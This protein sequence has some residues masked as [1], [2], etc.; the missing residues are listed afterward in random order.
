MNHMDVENTSQVLYSDIVSDNSPADEV[1]KSTAQ[2]RIPCESE[3][4]RLRVS[5]VVQGVGFRP[6]VY[7]IATALGL[8]GWVLNDPDGVLIEIEA[9]TAALDEFFR[10]L[11]AEA[12]PLAHITAVVTTIITSGERMAVATPP[13]SGFFIRASGQGGSHL[14]LVPPD[15]HVCA[16]CLAEMRDS[17]GR[18]YGYPFINC[19]NCG[20]RYSLIE[21]LPYDRANTTM[22]HFLMCSACQS[23]Y[24]D[25]ADRRY[26]AQPNACPSCGPQITLRDASACIAGAADALQQ[27]ITVLLA[28]QIVA[29]KSTG[30]FHLAV[31]ARNPDAVR[32]LRLR[33]QRDKKPFAVMVESLAAARRL[34]HCN[35]H[36]AGLL[37]A[38]ARPIVLLRKRPNDLAGAVA[39]SSPNLGIM[40]AS[41][42]LHY[43]L[44]ADARLPVLVMT[45][46]NRSGYPI[47]FRNE[48]AQAQL[49]D[50]A[51][52]ILEHNRDIQMR[53]DD[54]VVRCS[55]HPELG[56]PLVTFLRR[57]RGY[58]PYAVEV[59][60]ALA[61][62][63]AYGAELKATVALGKR[64]CVCISQHIGD[65]D[66]DDMYR[67]HQETVK[68]LTQLYAVQPLA[69]ACN[70]SSRPDAFRFASDLQQLQI[71]HHHAH[72]AGCI[73]ENRL[74]GTVLGVVFDGAGDG[75]DGSDY[76]GG[77]F[78]IGDV[79]HIERVAHLR[80]FPLSGR[81]HAV[82]KPIFTAL[83][84]VLDSFPDP[85]AVL[86]SVPAFTAPG[87]RA[88]AYKQIWAGSLNVCRASGMEC[89]F[90]GIAV[91]LGL[92]SCDSDEAQGLASLEGVLERDLTPAE[93]Y[94]F[95][96]G[97]TVSGVV[98]ELDYR[99]VVR[100]IVADLAAGVSV[101][102]ISRRFHS[103]IVQAIVAICGQL[104]DR[105][106]L[107][108]VVLTGSVFLNEFLLVN[109]MV[110]L[111]RAGFD[112]HCHRQ[113]PADDGGIAFGQI[114]V[115]GAQAAYGTAHA[116]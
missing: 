80:Y 27:T 56:G 54:S 102:V 66:N 70:M 30:G 98:P 112:P 94:L 63:V 81:D 74:D 12:P 103:G 101:A 114:I 89:F 62:V 35:E 85:S 71:R 100:G 115:A 93:P 36:E 64:K 40:L 32:R 22:R 37:N 82:K 75:G 8:C 87:I 59:P 60:Y 73:A 15:S 25:P 26:H 51:D 9:G 113:V 79:R 92:I 57:A 61:P 86:T 111:R 43:L 65:I 42:P 19:T 24:D 52:L 31:D 58:A 95:E 55:T 88:E 105:Y 33:K 78:F 110:Q 72:M 41:A 6:F 67:A 106:A 49:F 44:L 17:R 97:S 5:G 7:R 116:T 2:R 48:D 108:T 68:H 53:I 76:A 11:Q 34:A 83:A 18:R 38:S 13:A 3:R 29:I 69:V 16:A 107:N 4:R 21:H 50:V 46:G 14:A 47:V 109:S 20:P 96:T 10:I 84:L 77:E 23:E 104:R 45:S 28:G 90:D 1:K 39:P 91:L 99:P